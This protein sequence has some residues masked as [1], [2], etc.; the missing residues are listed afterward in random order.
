MNRILIIIVL[1]LSVLVLGS[2][3][4]FMIFAPKGQGGPLPILVAPSQS[5]YPYSPLISSPAPLSVELKVVRV[6]PN[7]DLSLD[8]NPVT[9]I[10]FTFSEDVDLDN[11]LLEVSPN[12]ETTVNP[13]ITAHT[14]TISPKKFWPEGI[15]TFTVTAGTKSLSGSVLKDTFTYKINVQYPKNPPADAD[16]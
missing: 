1:L 7:E 6:E 5:P 12:T 3:L 9:E 4:F 10:K 15:S 11:F 14:Y 2:Y 8:H 13:D 16:L